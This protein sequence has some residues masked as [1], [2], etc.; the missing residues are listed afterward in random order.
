VIRTAAQ[1]F[2]AYARRTGLIIAAFGNSWANCA[3]R[4]R[5]LNVYC[6]G[7]AR[8]A[9]CYRILPSDGYVFCEA[10][11]LKSCAVCGHAVLEL[12]RISAVGAHSRLRYKGKRAE[13]TFKALQKAVLF[14]V[15]GFK[16]ANGGFSLNYSEFGRV[17]K[18]YS[19]LKN[20]KCGLFESLDLPK[21]KGLL[22]K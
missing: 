1:G 3:Y 5:I 14:E 22:G 9:R 18:C 2:W 10:Y 12:E 15:E 20:L 21:G 17:K 7:K 8:Y 4:E 16:G 11:F 13:R 19:N 6:C